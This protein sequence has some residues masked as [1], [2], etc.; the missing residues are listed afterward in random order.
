MTGRNTLKVLTAV[1]L[2]A[3]FLVSNI[4][5]ISAHKR[6]SHKYRYVTA[7]SNYDVNERITAPVRRTRLGDQVK[8]PGG[9][10]VYCEVT[11]RYTLRRQTIDFWNTLSEEAGDGGRR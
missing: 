3:A 7:V 6:K 4:G 1:A 5:D 9:P 10:W 2:S 8:L 11:C